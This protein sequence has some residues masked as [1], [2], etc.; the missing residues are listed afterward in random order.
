[1]SDTHSQPWPARSPPLQP[2][3]TDAHP[4]CLHSVTNHL[5]P[6]LLCALLSPYFSPSVR[7]ILTSSAAAFFASFSKE[8]IDIDKKKD[9]HGNELKA[10]F[11]IPLFSISKG[12]AGGVYS[13]S[14]AMQIVFT[15]Q[16]QERFDRARQEGKKSG[17][18]RKI[19]ASFQQTSSRR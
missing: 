4:L 12:A 17:T 7:I 18:K 14:K 2:H 6:F 11:N 5:G 19:S 3:F 13:Q 15:N 1:M 8:S 16:L 10:G 9:H